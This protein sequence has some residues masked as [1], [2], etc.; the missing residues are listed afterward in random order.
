MFEGEVIFIFDALNAKHKRILQFIL[1][2]DKTTYDE[3]AA[4]TNQ[5]NKTVAKYVNDIRS[6]IEGSGVRLIVRQNKGIY[7]EGDKRELKNLFII[8]ILFILAQKKIGR[9]IYIQDF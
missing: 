2:R 3:L 1:D 5:S 8:S 6:M 7:L 4:Y 9:C